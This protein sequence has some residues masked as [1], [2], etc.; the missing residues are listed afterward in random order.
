[1]FFFHYA[2]FLSHAFIS[3]AIWKG[4]YSSKSSFWCFFKQN[5]ISLHSYPLSLW[6][7]KM[8]NFSQGFVFEKKILGTWVGLTITPVSKRTLYVIT[9]N[10]IQIEFD[11]F[12][13]NPV[14]EHLTCLWLRRKSKVS[15]LYLHYL[16]KSC[17]LL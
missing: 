6:I 16:K 3:Y 1:M 7:E 8:S 4:G 13:S 2:R 14:L 5:S 17:F 9:I 11:V 15:T 12:G 10:E